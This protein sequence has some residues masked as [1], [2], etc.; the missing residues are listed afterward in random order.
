MQCCALC[1]A[2]TKLEL[3]AKPS[4]LGHQLVQLAVPI[5]LR[6][7][8]SSSSQVR[9]PTPPLAP[10]SHMAMHDDAQQLEHAMQLAV[11]P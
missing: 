7:L 8:P 6:I 5:V 2:I 4:S 9:P 3:A 10:T 1:R 11:A